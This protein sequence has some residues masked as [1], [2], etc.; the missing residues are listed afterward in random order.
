M[1][2]SR[3]RRRCRT[4]ARGQQFRDFFKQFPACKA[5]GQ[6]PAAPRG[7]GMA[8]GSGFIISADGYAVTNNHVVKDADEVSVKLQR[9][10]GTTR[11]K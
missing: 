10:H 5:S 6:Q 2:Q 7:G 3:R 9:R 4:A 1:R 8:Q 11:P